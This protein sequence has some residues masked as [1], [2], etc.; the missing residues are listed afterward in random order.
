MLEVGY[1]G[2][3]HAGSASTRRRQS[4]QLPHADA[5][6]KPVV[7]SLQASSS[8]RR[9]GQRD[10]RRRRLLTDDLSSSDDWSDCQAW[11][12]EGP[13]SLKSEHYGD[14]AFLEQQP[15]LFDLVPRR[16]IVLMLLAMLAAG[17]F[18]GLEASYAWMLGRI[19]R[20]GASV[21]ASIWP[22]KAVWA[23]G[24]RH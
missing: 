12:D 5:V 11:P 10:D 1:S 3:T 22:S 9:H 15:R 16:L 14:A 13:P 19:A 24:S 8:F 23:A 7:M 4:Q 21:A 20:G 2:S 17:I 6:G 18:V